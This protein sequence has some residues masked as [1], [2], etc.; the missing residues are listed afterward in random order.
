MAQKI[1]GFFKTALENLVSCRTAQ[2]SRFAVRAIDAP[3]ER[4]QHRIYSV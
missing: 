2:M 1:R 4:Y 3:R